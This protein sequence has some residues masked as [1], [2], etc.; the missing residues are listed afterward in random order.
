MV[1]RGGCLLPQMVQ[2]DKTF[3]LKGA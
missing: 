1:Q 2:P 3:H